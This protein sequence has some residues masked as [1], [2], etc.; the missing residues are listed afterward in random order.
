M[1]T[2]ELIIYFYFFQMSQIFAENKIWHTKG[3]FVIANNSIV[4]QKDNVDFAKSSIVI[5]NNNTVFY[6]KA[7]CYCQ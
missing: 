2:N 4:I 6:K 5:A 1:A 3:S 7:F